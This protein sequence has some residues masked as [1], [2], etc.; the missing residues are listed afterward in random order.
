MP[1]DPDIAKSDGEREMY[2]SSFSAVS[3]WRGQ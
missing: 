1:E 3:P 2:A